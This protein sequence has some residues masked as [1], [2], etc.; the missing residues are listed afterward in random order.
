MGSGGKRGFGE[1]AAGLLPAR[2]DAGKSFG[3]FFRG[4]R[5]VADVCL[6]EG[7]GTEGWEA[8]GEADVTMPAWCSR[9]CRP[10]DAP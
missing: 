8:E 4:A 2:S 1:A 3:V 7:T 6:G 10:Q 5:R 9:K